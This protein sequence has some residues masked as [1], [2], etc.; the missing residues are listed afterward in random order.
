MLC[1]VSI[2]GLYVVFL[3]PALR[4][5]RFETKDWHS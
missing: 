2:H 1:L 5:H 3:G 4:I